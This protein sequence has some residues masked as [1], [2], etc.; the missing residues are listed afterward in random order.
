MNCWHCTDFPCA[1]DDDGAGGDDAS[2]VSP[3]LPAGV[4]Y[5]DGGFRLPRMAR[6]Y[7]LKIFSSIISF[8]PTSLALLPVTSPCLIQLKLT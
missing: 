6:K 8:L 7:F 5:D 2:G 4:I 3:M 1:R